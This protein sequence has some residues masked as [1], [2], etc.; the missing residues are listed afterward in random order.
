M[1]CDARH[2]R[3]LVDYVG[4]LDRQDSKLRT[5]RHNYRDK[6][7][8]PLTTTSDTHLRIY[9]DTNNKEDIL[10][11]DPDDPP[12]D[13]QNLENLDHDSSGPALT[14]ESYET[15]QP[16]LQ[17]DVPQ[18]SD[19]SSRSSSTYHD[20]DLDLKDLHLDLLYQKNLDLDPGKHVHHGEVLEDLSRGI[21]RTLHRKTLA[22]GDLGICGCCAAISIL[23]AALDLGIKLPI[24]LEVKC[25]YIIHE[26]KRQWLMQGRDI[27]KTIQIGASDAIGNIGDLHPDGD[28]GHTYYIST[29]D[30]KG[31][32]CRRPNDSISEDK[33]CGMDSTP[34]G[35][36][37]RDKSSKDNG[38]HEKEDM[39]VD[40]PQV[41]DAPLTILTID[42]N[43]Q[44]NNALVKQHLVEEEIAISTLEIQAIKEFEN[45]T[46]EHKLLDGTPEE[47]MRYFYIDLAR[48]DPF[49]ALGLISRSNAA[50]DERRINE[51]IRTI[52]G[53]V[54]CNGG[55]DDTQNNTTRD[56]ENK[57]L[58]TGGS[59]RNLLKSLRKLHPERYPRP[60]TLRN[61]S[62]AFADYL[63][64]WDH[65][66]KAKQLLFAYNESSN[67]IPSFGE[68][69]E[70]LQDENVAWKGK[71]LRIKH[72]TAVCWAP[73]SRSDWNNFIEAW[74]STATLRTLTKLH[75]VDIVKISEQAR[76]IGFQGTQ[77]EWARFDD[78][79]FIGNRYITSTQVTYLEFLPAACRQQRAY[80]SVIT[81]GEHT[82]GVAEIEDLN[83]K[84]V[85][86]T[87]PVDEL[88]VETEWDLG[89]HAHRHLYTMLDTDKFRVHPPCKGLP[90]NKGRGTEIIRCEAL[91][92][93][94]EGIYVKAIALAKLRLEGCLK[95]IG[96]R[97]SCQKDVYFTLH[98]DPGFDITRF[99]DL[100]RESTTISPLQVIITTEASDAEWAARLT[101]TF[102]KSPCL[103]ATKVT[104]TDKKDAGKPSTYAA[105]TKSAAQ[106]QLIRSAVDK[107]NK[108]PP[109][110]AMQVK[111]DTE[112]PLPTEQE[113]LNW[114]DKI[115]NYKTF[116]QLHSLLKPLENGKGSIIF[117]KDE[118]A[119]WNGHIIISQISEVMARK[120]RDHIEQTPLV[121]RHR[122][123]YFNLLQSL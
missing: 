47:V 85:E 68:I 17:E 60:V 36:R 25:A 58:E 4:N 108:D 62:H 39:Q 110:R 70:T 91:T 121:I 96:R 104:R 89:E 43:H 52:Q 9:S 86:L 83:W 82:T 97:S 1:S 76:L 11:L 13:L 117:C 38:T 40:S 59:A 79:N 14:R 119:R 33:W 57:L 50:V 72:H 123:F 10:D 95:A 107:G 81:V 102:E 28:W 29:L 100:M 92:E 54:A 46:L 34:N 93:M 48:K 71:L 26:H 15:G 19:S 37:P 16:H 116:F 109:L 106:I 115:G 56:W 8:N 103:C 7:W 44:R 84:K 2:S 112:Y 18:A 21:D 51:R 77:P 24:H 12:T 98:H 45:R 111:L 90:N 6:R 80:M 69:N 118:E 87:N 78:S 101:E 67:P 120:I 27:R 20:L 23:T 22:L 66:K 88:V 122:C 105:I 64:R 114:L 61:I 53:I 65:T 55:Y 49:E 41:A 74:K 75:M 35:K 5:S 30:H 99:K 32:H 63:Y 73:K 113:V 31:Q 42:K 3:L 94:G